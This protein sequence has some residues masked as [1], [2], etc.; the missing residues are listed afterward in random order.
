MA[1]YTDITSRPGKGSRPAQN[2]S[3]KKYRDGYD[4]I[5]GKKRSKPRTMEVVNDKNLVKCT[6]CDGY[7]EL[8]Q[9]TLT[10]PCRVCNGLGKLEY[11]N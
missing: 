11:A 6:E 1:N 7:G 9:G 10:V 4:R 2:V 5:F 3:T 8:P